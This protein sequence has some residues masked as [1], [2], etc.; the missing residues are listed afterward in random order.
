MIYTRFGNEVRITGLQDREWVTAVRQY[1]QAAR[2]YHISDL[3]AD[4]GAPEIDKALAPF[5]A[6]GDQDQEPDQPEMVPCT[7][8]GDG[9]SQPDPDCPDCGGNGEVPA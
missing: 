8:C 2:E 3:R 1:D 9:F 5:R 6:Q 4:G 7:R